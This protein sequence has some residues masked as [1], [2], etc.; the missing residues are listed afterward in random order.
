MLLPN[1]GRWVTD[2]VNPNVMTWPGGCNADSFFISV[3]MLIELEI[4]ILLAERRDVRQ[5]AILRTWLDSSMVRPEFASCLLSVDEAVADFAV[6][7][8]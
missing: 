3:I 7:E 6:T 4:G 8:V 5:A 1:C 2:R